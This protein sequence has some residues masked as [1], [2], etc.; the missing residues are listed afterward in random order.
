[1]NS[2]KQILAY[3]MEGARLN[4]LR[5]LCERENIRLTAVAPA[6][7]GAP[8]ALLAGQMAPAEMAYSAASLSSASAS[9]PPV[10]E[11]ML[12]LSGFDSPALD[13]LLRQLREEDLGVSLKAVL[14]GVNRTWSGK[15]LCGELK[16][17]RRAHGA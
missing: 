6:Q 10:S 2:E 3:R 9:L 17:E 12:V 8:L 15:M 7:E 11:E 14:T 13:R 5:G 4:A 1:M 16:R